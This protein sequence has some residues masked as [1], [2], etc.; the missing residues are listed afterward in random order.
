MISIDAGTTEKLIK[1]WMPLDQYTDVTMRGLRNGDA[2][3]STGGS[4][5]WYE[6]FEKAK[7]DTV[8]QL[9]EARKKW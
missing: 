6:Q 8:A 7:G 2:I 3:I 4:L 5:A 9:E 1:L